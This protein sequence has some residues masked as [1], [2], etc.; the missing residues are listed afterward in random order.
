[1]AEIA[2][3]RQLPKNQSRLLRYLIWML[4]FAV[5]SSHLLYPPRT[6]RLSPAH[7]ATIKEKGTRGGDDHHLEL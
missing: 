1:A 6:G 4:P 3:F 5:C 2:P 7:G